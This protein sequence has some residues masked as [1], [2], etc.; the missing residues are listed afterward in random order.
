MP[1]KPVEDLVTTL[2]DEQNLALGWLALA[3]LAVWP[4][5]PADQAPGVAD[6]IE[7]AQKVPLKA[8]PKKDTRFVV[9]V[10]V[11]T[12]LL[13]F[14]DEANKRVTDPAADRPRADTLR[15]CVTAIA[16]LTKDPDAYWGEWLRRAVPAAITQAPAAARDVALKAVRCTLTVPNKWDYEGGLTEEHV[17]SGVIHRGIIAVVAPGRGG[18]ELF[19]IGL[20]EPQA[21]T[22]KAE[23]S[24][25]LPIDPYRMGYV[26]R[27]TL[28]T[29]L[30]EDS[31]GGRYDSVVCTSTATGE[32]WTYDAL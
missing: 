27:T 10:E 6:A 3:E 9:A 28:M 17:A 15:Q 7:Q 16:R 8:P 1:L 21:R 26:F 18:R 4:Q 5:L 20:Y 11:S 25:L 24:P 12:A 23:F 14:V 29:H 22:I 19:D 31:Y 13:S 30:L 2:S 32:V